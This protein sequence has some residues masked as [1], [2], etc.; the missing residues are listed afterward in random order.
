MSDSLLCEYVWLD[1]S[2]PRRLRSKT[3]VLKNWDGDLENLPV[4]NFDGSSTNQAP[5]N[6]SECLLQPVRAYRLARCHYVILCE[7][8]N[9]DGTPHASN[10]RANLRK[11]SSQYEP[12][13]YW[14]GFEQEYFI[15][16]DS[17]PLGFPVSGFP[18]AQGPYYCGVGSKQVKGRSFAEAHMDECLSM[19][20]D[21][22]GIN[23][24]VAL[25]Q[26]EFQCFSND[27]LKA[28]DD[29]WI[30]RYMLHRM[31][32]AHDYD[33]DFSPKPVS[34]DWN[35]SGCH[36]NF[37]TNYMR[38]YGGREHF[39]GVCEAMG[40]AHRAHI[41]NYGEGNENRLTGLH[42]TQHIDQFSYGVGDR[43]A[44]IRIPVSVASNDWTG[45]LEDRRP[46]SN[47]D[48]YVVAALIVNT[49]SAK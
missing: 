40:E 27:T 35:G 43:S 32:E 47:C 49:T 31:S 46:A 4:W 13:C 24:E 20:I 41:E 44:S 36:T 3:K 6:N 10:T 30:S 28:C 2:V 21:I 45:Y 22:T 25:G 23:A 7:V 29:L 16:K 18:S 34:G 9:C 42:E 19:G 8:Q 17:A 33:I 1:G 37:S 14:W 11:L 38:S 39:V 26:W 5:G 12:A 15:M 48:P